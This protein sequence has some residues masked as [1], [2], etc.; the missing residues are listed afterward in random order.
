MAVASEL[1]ETGVS[2][3]AL[4]RLFQLSSAALPIGAFAYSQGLEQAVAL[5][6]VK[7]RDSAARWISGM[8]ERSLMS[9]DVPIF[10]RLHRAFAAQDSAGLKMVL[11][12]GLDHVIVTDVN[13]AT[14]PG[15]S[16]STQA[17]LRGKT[18]VL[19]LQCLSVLEARLHPAPGRRRR[20]HQ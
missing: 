19:S 4:M 18:R 10:A 1:S 17:L 8:L 7:D 9:L 3:V 16:L 14:N 11:A 12:F 20:A 6:D 5:G 2:G 13:P 15:R